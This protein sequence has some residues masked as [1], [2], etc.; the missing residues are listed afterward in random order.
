MRVLFP[1]NPSI[2]LR[3]IEPGRPTMILGRTDL[4]I[5]MHP[6][7]RR[8]QD[9]SPELWRPNRRTMSPE[10]RL[11]A[12]TTSDRL[13]Q[14]VRTRRRA[15]RVPIPESEA[16]VR[17]LNCRENPQVALLGVPVEI[18]ASQ[19]GT[20]M[21]PA[22]FRT[23]GFAPRARSNSDLTSK[24]TAISG[25]TAGLARM[26]T[27]PDNAKYYDESRPGFDRSANAPVLLAR[28]GAIPIFMGGDHS[29]S[30]GSV[31]GVARY[32]R[33]QGPRRFSCCGSM[34]MPTTTRRKRPSPATCT[35]CRRRS[36]AANPALTICSASSRAPHRPRS[37]GPV[38]DQLDRSA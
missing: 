17:K 30:M 26:A 20:L 2:T 32:W 33:E 4:G 34:P 10:G 8:R 16:D 36:C 22:A 24:T 37:A 3:V 27:P 35:A 11:L 13:F 7:R 29:L 31:N 1:S 38:R 5:C 21:G 15:I 25:S 18:G 9:F 19:A 28:S 12:T 6:R 23:A 14:G